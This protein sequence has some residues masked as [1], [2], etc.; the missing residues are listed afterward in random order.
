[1]LVDILVGILKIFLII[2]TIVALLA[3]L[4]VIGMSVEGLK[5]KWFKD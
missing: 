2:M 3:P 5:S 4:I 1:M